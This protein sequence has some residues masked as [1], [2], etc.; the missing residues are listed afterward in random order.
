[1][2]YTNP[3][4]QTKL[5]RPHITDDLVARPR[6]FDQLDCN[7]GKPLT[8][9]SAPAGYGKST[10]LS[11]WLEG[12]DCPYAWLSLDEY[13]DNLG[14]FLSYFLAAIDRSF[15]GVV[16]DSLAMLSLTELPPLRYLAST[17]INELDQIDGNFILVI[18]DYHYINQTAIHDLIN[19][20]LLHPTGRMQ[21]VLATRTDPPLSLVLLRAKS[22]AIEI[23]IYELRFTQEETSLLLHKLLGQYIKE[24]EIQV[25]DQQ[26]EG[27][28]TGLRL[29]ALTL[30]DPSKVEQV[31]EHMRGDSQFVRDYLVSEVIAQLPEATYSFL[32]KTSILDRF[33]GPLC[34]VVAGLDDTIYDGQSYLEWLQDISL[35]IVPLDEQGQWFRYHQLMQEY[36]QHE[37][38]RTYRQAEIDELHRRAGDWMSQN[39]MI[40]QALHHLMKGGDTLGAIQLVAQHRHRLLDREESQRLE[41]WLRMFD[42]GTIEASPE[43]SIIEAWVLT[44]YAMIKPTFVA[45]ERV[46][47]LL[48]EAELP[49]EIVDPIR[50][51]IL[52]LHANLLS[53]FNRYEEAMAMVEP[54]RELLPHN[55]HSA[56]ASIYMISSSGLA[57][58][59]KPEL[60]EQSLLVGLND[61]QFGDS[62]KQKSLL[63]YALCRLRLVDLNPHDLISMATRYEKYGQQNNLQGAEQ[64]AQYFL[65]CAHYY[66]ND[67]SEAKKRFSKLVENPYKTNLLFYHQA[68]CGLA[69]TYLALEKSKQALDLF[70][71]QLAE[72]MDQLS[73]MFISILKVCQAE[74]ALAQGK[75][76]DATRW[77]ESYDP[78][79]HLGLHLFYIPQLAY[80]KVLLAQNTKESLVQGDTLLNQISEVARNGYFRSVLISTL[81][82]QALLEDIQGN[83]QSAVSKLEE[84]IRL[85]EPHLVIRP[86][87]DMGPRMANLLVQFG[88]SGI[89]KE[90][91]ARLLD[92]FPQSELSNISSSQM[93]MVEPLTKREREILGL[94]GQHLSN[95]DIAEQLVISTG[96]V[97][98]HT[99]KIY[100]KLGVNS[101]GQAVNEAK[102]V[103]ILTTSKL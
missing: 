32:L 24:A 43:L 68:V 55:W 83:E 99:H 71:D 70:R 98:Q 23:R 54:A 8:L 84:A 79:P 67:L 19:E 74:V 57:Q 5:Y 33:S 42:R 96:T 72:M 15:P 6:L 66:L 63:L 20:L 46:E 88:E 58:M 39:G 31:I 27:W 77:T 29:A 2:E 28:V 45:L 76:S 85:A 9:V 40:D 36:L 13:D 21:L 94:L 12:V 95:Q 92:A 93:H 64:L 37:L 103:G 87:V 14:I 82:I 41:R 50:G 102:R 26:F 51:E 16:K 25:I 56:H 52:I 100:Q 11:S 38:K 3:L 97:R 60:A 49:Q 17:L 90:Y 69:L 91:I 78:Q 59:G 18:D 35:F 61:N 48:A 53:W 62:P 101:R 65:G 80:A 30:R 89:S 34:D 7:R 73:P 10:L 86:F 81:L 44:G 47:K 1:M 75:V 4:N 22:L